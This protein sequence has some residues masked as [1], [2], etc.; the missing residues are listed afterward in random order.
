MELLSPAHF[1]QYAPYRRAEELESQHPLQH[2]DRRPADEQDRPYRAADAVTNLF[3]AAH[4]R[5]SH[6]RRDAHESISRKGAAFRQDMRQV[7]NP[8]RLP[9]TARSCSP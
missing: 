8:G 9:P 3:V 6:E 4:S 2:V 7:S 1:H 5:A